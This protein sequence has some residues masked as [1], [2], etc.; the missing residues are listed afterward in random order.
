[1]YATPPRPPALLPTPSELKRPG[2][3]H[4]AWDCGSSWETLIPRLNEYS[5]YSAYHLIYDQFANCRAS[6]IDDYTKRLSQ[7]YSEDFIHPYNIRMIENMMSFL[8]DVV[9]PAQGNIKALLFNFNNVRQYGNP[10]SF[11][12]TIYS[13]DN[14]EYVYDINGTEN[15]RLGGKRKKP[16]KSTKNKKRKTRRNRRKE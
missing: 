15:R 10:Y 6:R 5:K 16:S 14:T 7:G 3:V 1:M 2:E 9:A 12:V 11:R 13:N 8:N 4:S